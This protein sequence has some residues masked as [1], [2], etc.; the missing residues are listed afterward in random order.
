[1]KVWIYAENGDLFETF[2]DQNGN[3]S[4]YNLPATAAGVQYLIYS[5]HHV[6]DVFDATQI[7]TL[8]TDTSVILKSSN[9]QSKPLIVDLDLY[10]IVP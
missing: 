8:A 10:T 2:T 7:E 6:V 9:T 5:E 1:V 3:F 4:F